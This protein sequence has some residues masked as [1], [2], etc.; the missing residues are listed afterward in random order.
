LERQAAE[1]HLALYDNGLALRLVPGLSLSALEANR[2]PDDD[3]HP[4]LSFQALIHG[5]DALL[6]EYPQ[7]ELAAV[8]AAFERLRAAWCDHEAT[9]RSARL[10]AAL[11]EFSTSLRRLGEKIEPI[12]RRLPLAHRD[13]QILDATAYPPPGKTDVEVLY[14]R[15][16]P[17]FWSWP[18]D[19][20]AVVLLGLSL[21]VW[22]RSMFGLGLLALAAGQ[23]MVLIGLALRWK[24]T[25]LVPL[26]G[27]FET[28][29]F[30]GLGTAV[31]GIGFVF[32]PI[33]RSGWQAG[34]RLCALRRRDKALRREETPLWASAAWRKARWGLVP[35]RVAITA[36]LA[37]YLVRIPY[38]GEHGY[39]ELW[40]RVPVGALLT[41][42]LVFKQQGAGRLIEEVSARRIFA[43]V[44]AA[45]ALG[46]ALLACYAPETIL[47]RS[48]ESP[49]PILRHNFWLLVHVLTIT[50]SY[51]AGALAWGLGNVA[52]G[53]YL[54][55]RYRPAGSDSAQGKGSQTKR[56]GAGEDQSETP[57]TRAE[58]LETSQAG[59]VR[60]SQRETDEVP[61][62]ATLLP[63]AGR[64]PQAAGPASAADSVS[65]G[66]PRPSSAGPPKNQRSDSKHSG[67]AH[68]PKA[69]RRLA[70]YTYR[71]LQIAVLL[72]AAGTILGA[73]WGDVA[74][75]RFWGWDPKEVWALVTLLVY[76]VILHG[77]HIGWVG[78]FGIALAAVAGFGAIVMAWYGVNFVL[79]SGLHAY[80]SGAGG[81]AAAGPGRGGALSCSPAWL[82]DHRRRPR[83]AA[84]ASALNNYP[85]MSGN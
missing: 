77:R 35:V 25:G 50:A 21:V 12:R 28:V 23:A 36:W 6:A 70:G 71:A 55:G 40:P 31:L 9:D 1:A 41:A 53:F 18:L 46:A 8:R 26:T 43:L 56:Y 83:L 68:A 3:A 72:L 42:P 84:G 22:R 80:A 58:T 39:F 79:G 54:L 59:P 49:R 16:D 14:N 15:L 34:W 64:Q 10:G 13:E 75:G 27:M 24:I 52:M 5:S 78:Q 19:L 69:C 7:E 37:W 51:A 85:R 33:L 67:C 17:F 66:P 62:E 11:D 45:V 74:W 76:M 73:M 30:M 4:W 44:G 48:L 2:T 47:S 63:G 29:V 82:S 57:E 61:V 38:L 65:S 60:P 32:S 81:Q 20:A